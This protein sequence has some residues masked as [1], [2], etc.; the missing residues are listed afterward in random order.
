LRY[1]RNP[2]ARD[3]SGVKVPILDSNGNVERQDRRL[4]Q[5]D[6][7]PS[8]RSPLFELAIVLVRFDHVVRLIV[9]ANHAIVRPAAKLCVAD[10]VADWIWL[11]VPQAAKWQ[12]IAN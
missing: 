7:T 1:L 5:Q 4:Q 11:T 12:R 2:R 10:C 8:R 6:G 3:E 9:N